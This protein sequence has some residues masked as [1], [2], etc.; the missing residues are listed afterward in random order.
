[1]NFIDNIDFESAAS[2]PI[3]G[4]FSQLPNLVDPTIARTVYFYDID[5]F[6]EVYG[7]AT[8]ALAAWLGSRGI[9]CKTIE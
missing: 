9:G 3:D 7:Y 1:V 6:T 8:I 5:V 4:V 2:G